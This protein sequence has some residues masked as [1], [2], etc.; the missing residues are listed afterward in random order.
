MKI[1]KKISQ[2]KL[3]LTQLQGKLR[4]NFFVNVSVVEHPLTKAMV[5]GG[6]QTG[7]LTG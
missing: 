3:Y 4:C 7:A 1:K 2:V 5:T 6:G